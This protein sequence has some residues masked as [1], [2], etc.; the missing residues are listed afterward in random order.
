MVAKKGKLLADIKDLEEQRAILLKP[1]D[2]E[3][4]KV[5]KLKEDVEEFS[6]L[7]LAQ[8]QKNQIQDDFLAKKTEDLSKREE[9]VKRGEQ[10]AN[11][12]IILAEEQQK[13]AEKSLKEAKKY[14]EQTKESLEIREKEVAEREKQR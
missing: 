11:E 13:T 4:A 2:E 14:E 3:W 8:Q 12:V 9:L 5:T 7:V 6:N 10:R 1:L